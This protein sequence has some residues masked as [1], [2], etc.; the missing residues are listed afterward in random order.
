MDDIG[1]EPCLKDVWLR[2]AVDENISVFDS[3]RSVESECTK[4][5][6]RRWSTHCTNT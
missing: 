2:R 3:A 4:S 1:L 5:K 6:L